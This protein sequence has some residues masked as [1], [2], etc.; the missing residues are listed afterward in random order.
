MYSQGKTEIGTIH[1]YPMSQEEVQMWFTTT[2]YYYCRK[3]KILVVNVISKF[4]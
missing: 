2:Y 1:N 4:S 3:Q